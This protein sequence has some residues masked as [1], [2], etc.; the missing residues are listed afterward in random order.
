MYGIITALIPF[1]PRPVPFPDCKHTVIVV[2]YIRIA[3]E[4]YVKKRAS[5]KT[6]VDHGR[7]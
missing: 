3:E 5:A 6:V 4:S 7:R 2:C 1:I